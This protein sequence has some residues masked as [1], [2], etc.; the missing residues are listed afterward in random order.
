MQAYTNITPEDR[1]V[2]VIS[3][4]HYLSAKNGIGKEGLERILMDMFSRRPGLSLFDI[5]LIC[6][7]LEDFYRSII[8]EQQ[9]HHLKLPDRDVLNELKC[10]C[11]KLI[12]KLSGLAENHNIALGRPS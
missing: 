11:K 9:E 4:N 1:A 10:N 6:P 2:I 8:D 3:V 7:V 12:D 5:P